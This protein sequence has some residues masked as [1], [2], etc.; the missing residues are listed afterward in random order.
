[1][2]AIHQDVQEKVFQEIVNEVGLN[3]EIEAD[4]L[5]GF[6]YMEMVI[7]EAM[8]LFPV[9]PMIARKCDTNTKICES[10]F[11]M[12]CKTFLEMTSRKNLPFYKEVL[13][14]HSLL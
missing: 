1:M 2:L 4:M 6:P 12:H 5:N 10:D 13:S 14:E 8:R 11:K 9:G 7:K 3:E